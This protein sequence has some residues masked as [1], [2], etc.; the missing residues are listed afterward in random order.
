MGDG[1][2]VVD[3]NIINAKLLR[4]DSLL[5]GGISIDGGKIVKV[6]KEANL[7]TSAARIN[8][9]R[10]VAL[11]GMIDVHVHLRALKL[12]YKEDFLTGTS[13]AACGGF[14][15]VLDMPNSDPKTD[16]LRH[17][18]MRRRE[19]ASNILVNVGFYAVFPEEREET[20]K[21][22]ESPIVGFK[23]N[24]SDPW[25]RLDFDDDEVL[26]SVLSL[27]AAQGRLVAVHAEDHIALLKREEELRAEGADR[28]EDWL[29]LHS[30]EVEV[31]AV[32][33]ILRVAEKTGPILHFCHVSTSEAVEAIS[34]A[35]RRGL[36]A[37]CEVT[38]HHL[39]LTEE[40]VSRLGGF[41][42]MSPPLRSAGVA[43]ELWERLR[44][45]LIDI[46]ADDHAPHTLEEKSSKRF[47]DVKPGLPGLETTLPLLLDRVNR[48]E[49][50]LWDVTRLLSSGPAGLFNLKGK[51]SLE[52]GCDGDVVLVDLKERWVIDSSEFKS[53][54]KYS[55]FDGVTVVGRPVKTFVAGSL[56]MDRGEIVAEPG[57]GRLLD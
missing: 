48:G 10:M 24:F 52:E 31:S 53:K 51:G 2:L 17:L 19:A 15:T 14:T 43:R 55:P 11:P 40:A 8:G 54:A 49:L 47:W 13:A 50:S 30:P 29:R 26:S 4:G 16:S 25:S 1:R 35:R 12:S 41:A 3:L 28:P 32:H 9:G 22:A 34:D 20:M 27:A 39:F 5:E 37:T 38:P 18:E 21:L 7:P 33:R 36:R 23:I 42:I 57:C 46:V 6:G 44:S 45:G 56:V